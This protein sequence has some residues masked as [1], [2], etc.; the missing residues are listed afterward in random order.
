M[1]NIININY[2]FLRKEIDNSIVL[3]L[4]YQNDWK[5]KDI[6]FKLNQQFL[7]ISIDG[8]LP[9]WKIE[10]TNPMLLDSLKNKET[11]ILINGGEQGFSE[12][13][14]EPLV[15]KKKNKP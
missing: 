15:E 6:N 3:I 12:G 11:A 7:E 10:I 14:I 5:D 1:E 2:S 4:D 8:N 9:R 13:L